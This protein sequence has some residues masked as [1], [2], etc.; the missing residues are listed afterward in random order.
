MALVLTPPA[1]PGYRTSNW[2]LARAVGR[3]TSPFTGAEKSY[4]YSGAW[5]E[6]ELSL[7]PMTRATAVEWL[8]FLTRASAG[9]ATF[10]LND[11]DAKSILGGFSGTALTLVTNK[12]LTNNTNKTITFARATQ[13][14]DGSTQNTSDMSGAGNPFATA[15]IGGYIN[16]SGADDDENNGTYEVVEVTDANNI[17]VLNNNSRARSSDTGVN[18][19]TNVRGG[20]ALE[21]T[22]SAASGT[23]PMLKKG[24]WLSL[25]DAFGIP[26]QLFMV[27]EDATRYNAQLSVRV[28]PSLRTDAA[29]ALVV[30]W[31]SSVAASPAP[32]GLF[33]LASPVAEWS[34]DHVSR[35]GVSIAVRESISG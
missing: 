8:S 4:E 10:L 26:S 16:V 22:I 3:S 13:S 23:N 18:I 20:N 15:Y 1:S 9:N 7:P 5:W 35:Y 21:V 34:A 31:T 17:E 2:H 29:D 14:V 24:D 19:Q 6:C 11:P 32:Y 27:A 28:E 25:Y 30:H 33:R 12:S